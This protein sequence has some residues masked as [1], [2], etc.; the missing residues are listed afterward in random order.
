VRVRFHP[1]MNDAGG[2]GGQTDDPT[3]D[4][5]HKL[6]HKFTFWEIT[7]GTALAFRINYATER[8][9]DGSSRNG[10]NKGFVYETN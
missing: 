7:P 3:H 5:A 9:V 10:L 1:L 6:S 4:C 8:L 2:G